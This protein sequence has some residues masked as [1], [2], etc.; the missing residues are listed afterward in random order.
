MG[1]TTTDTPKIMAPDILCLSQEEDNEVS[2]WWS[3][4]YILYAML[5]G[6]YPQDNVKVRELFIKSKNKEAK[7]NE[8][9]SFYKN[10]KFPDDIKINKKPKDLIIKL[11]EFE[12]SKRLGYSSSEQIKNHPFFEGVNWD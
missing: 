3:F 4:G 12:T 1:P 2:D 6:N 9:A 8:L 5:I 11:L 10:L 7:K